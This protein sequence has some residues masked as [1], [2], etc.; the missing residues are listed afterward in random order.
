MGLIGNVDCCCTCR[1]SAMTM[2]LVSWVKDKL[3]VRWIVE[4]RSTRKI[5]SMVSCR[6]SVS[7]VLPSYC[8]LSCTSHLGKEDSFVRDTPPYCFVL[9]CSTRDALAKPR[10][11]VQTVAVMVPEGL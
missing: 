7:W 3:T 4:D 2:V 10:H 8:E 6:L 9:F 1:I 11:M 5:G